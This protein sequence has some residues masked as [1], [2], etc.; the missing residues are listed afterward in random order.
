[1]AGA[2]LRFG[3]RGAVE[4]RSVKSPQEE[5]V[6]IRTAARNTLLLAAA[7]LT[8]GGVMASCSGK[9]SSS[10]DLARELGSVQLAIRLASGAE[11]RSV[12]YTISGNAITP[13]TGT[14]DVSGSNAAPSVLV[15]G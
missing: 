11:I 1:M 4:G 13:R 14:I 7:L 5:V 6:M 3:A 8:T 12:A 10:T 2:S 9:K 15:T